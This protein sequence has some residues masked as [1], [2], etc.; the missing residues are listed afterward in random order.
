MKTLKHLM[1]RNSVSE[2]NVF[3][4]IQKINF[5]TYSMGVCIPKIP[6]VLCN[7]CKRLNKIHQMI[8]FE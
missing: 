6:K 1:A 4:S 5:K 2:S 7:G 3:F 8:L